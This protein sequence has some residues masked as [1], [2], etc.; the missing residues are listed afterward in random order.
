M[1]RTPRYRD[2]HVGG[3]EAREEFERAMAASAWVTVCGPPGVGKSRCVATWLEGRGEEVCWVGLAG[4]SGE[5]AALEALRRALGVEREGAELVPQLAWALARRGVEVLVWDDADTSG[6]G[7]RAE[8]LLDEVDGLRVVATSRGRLGPRGERVV[9]LGPLPPGQGEEL[10]RA[11]ALAD[12]VECEEADAEALR[13]ISRALDG[14]PLALELAASWLGV[15]GARE[16]AARLEGGDGLLDEVPL[17]DTRYGT[18]HQAVAWSWSQL[19]EVERSVLSQCACWVGAFTL[20]DAV[21]F[22]EADGVL[23][24]LRRLNGMGLTRTSRRGEA[25]FELYALV[26]DVALGSGDPALIEAARARLAAWLVG[27]ARR[28]EAGERAWETAATLVEDA[29]S[30]EAERVWLAV[31][32]SRVARTRGE[33]GRADALL[34]RVS[35]QDEPHVSLERARVRFAQGRYVESVALARA[36]REAAGSR[37]DEVAAA[38]E[39]SMGALYAGDMEGAWAELEGLEEVE[40]PGLA[41]QRARLFHWAGRRDEALEQYERAL[42]WARRGGDDDVAARAT[43]N[44]GVFLLDVSRLDEARRHLEDAA[45]RHERAGERLRRAQAL[46]SLGVLEMRER[47]LVAAREAFD[48]ARRIFEDTGHRAGVAMVEANAGMLWLDHGEV[49]R[50]EASATEA[51][52]LTRGD[53]DAVTRG[54]ARLILGYAL[55]T[56]G[57]LD[58]AAAVLSQGLDATDGVAHAQTR[59]SLWAAAGGLAALRGEVKRAKGLFASARGEMGDGEH[60][61]LAELIGIHEL[62]VE[63]AVWRSGDA[64]KATPALFRAL[65]ALG[66]RPAPDDERSE[67]LRLAQRLVERALGARG[68][69]LLG[70]TRAEPDALIVE[71]EADAMRAPGSA[72]LDLSR[73]P[74]LANMA[75]ALLDRRLEAPGAGI[76]PDELTELVWPGERIAPDA[77]TNRLHVA[78]AKLRRLGLRDLLLREGEGY[79]LD[80]E[81]EVVR[82]GA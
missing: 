74:A 72:W 39:A 69:A 37:D 63:L 47:A 34:S 55:W 36:S 76:E 4:V 6:L 7:E 80:A 51:L 61:V 28:G 50:A 71:G 2:A 29:G 44:L 35:G 56:A 75:R 21:A 41:L 81:V 23:G 49:A 52:A 25:T 1:A 78:I 59:V 11:R 57:S 79:L 42:A 70:L 54:H 58:E 19:G 65:D 10:L 27:R 13:R 3:D 38:L 82:V 66:A 40:R 68:E 46:N 32:A 14:L 45:T 22:V 5:D 17:D 53:E 48:Q 30:S 16:L 24:A 62:H 64:R 18:L 15:M 73:S 67:P 77:A 60:D 9:T 12:G 31:F 26:R 33:L 20:D 43:H 8:A